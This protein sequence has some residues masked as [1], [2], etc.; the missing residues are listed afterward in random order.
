MGWLAARWWLV[1]GLVVGR[2]GGWRGRRCDRGCRGCR[3]GWSVSRPR[4]SRSLRGGLGVSSWLLLLLLLVVVV[5]VVVRMRPGA[6]RVVVVRAMSG[7]AASRRARSRVTQL[8]WPSSRR[9]AGRRV[10]TRRFCRAVVMSGAVV[11]SGA[12]DVG[13]LQ[14]RVMSTLP[15]RLKRRGRV[16]VVWLAAGSRVSVCVDRV[17]GGAESES[18]SGSV[19][20][21]VIRMVVETGVSRLWWSVAVSR[22]GWLTRKAA[23]A[24]SMMRR[25]SVPGGFVARGG[26]GLIGL[27]D[28]VVVWWLIAALDGGGVSGVYAGVRSIATMAIK[29]TT[30]ISRPSGKNAAAALNAGT[31]CGSRWWRREWRGCDRTGGQS[32]I[33]GE[34]WR[35]SG[36]G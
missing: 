24:S 33:A 26:V 13:A 7:L 22:P 20:W 27:V 3:A 4:M 11:V 15:G 10:R 17:G 23:G 29:E 28:W 6:S 18:G 35:V 1:W 30:R 9:T 32:G 34:W 31:G 25:G 12:S 2:R 21:V 5:V 8:G 19:Y 14:R 36:G 16:M